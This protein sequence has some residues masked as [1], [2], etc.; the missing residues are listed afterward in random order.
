[1]CTTIY[2]FQRGVTK[3][4]I[5]KKT[6]ET[7]EEKNR[8]IKRSNRKTM[9]T[10]VVRV[11]LQKKSIIAAIIRCST[12]FW[13]SINFVWLKIMCARAYSLVSQLTLTELQ[14]AGDNCRFGAGTLSIAVSTIWS[15]Y[16]TRIWREM[17]HMMS[18]SRVRVREL[19]KILKTNVRAMCVRGSYE[20]FILAAAVNNLWDTVWHRVICFG[21]NHILYGSLVALQMGYFVY[22]CST[23]HIRGGYGP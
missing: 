8:G 16:E 21:I 10:M 6:R 19:N 13:H 20:R 4:K 7:A 1:M 11:I 14:Q 3:I 2:L 15:N 17:E 23:G 9:T 22:T 5:N 18:V 12:C